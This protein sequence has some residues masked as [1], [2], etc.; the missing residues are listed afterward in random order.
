[1]SNYPDRQVDL[2]PHQLLPCPCP[3]FTCCVSSYFQSMLLDNMLSSD[4]ADL[5]LLQ[6][7]SHL[8]SCQLQQLV[9]WHS[10][11]PTRTQYA[12]EIRPRCS[13]T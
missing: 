10:S 6:Q 3:C 13:Y 5:R 11:L 4:H 2:A 8:L 7:L 1:M 9:Q 12:N